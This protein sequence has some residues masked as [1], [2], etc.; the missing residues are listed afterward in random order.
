[1]IRVEKRQIKEIPKRNSMRE[2]HIDGTINQIVIDFAKGKDECVECFCDEE[3]A[4]ANNF[5]K[6]FQNACKYLGI[7]NVQAVIRGNRVFLIKE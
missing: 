2:R 4:N 5:R 1:M 6:S 7:E 3:Y